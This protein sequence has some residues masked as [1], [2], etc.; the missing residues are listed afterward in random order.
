[1]VVDEEASNIAGFYIGIFGCIFLLSVAIW[2]GLTSNIIGGWIGSLIFILVGV[3]SFLLGL[4]SR[5][6]ENDPTREAPILL[7]SIILMIV[8]GAIAIIFII[9][10]T[11]FH[12]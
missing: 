10:S 2:G 5:Y 3:G 12:K 8:A 6:R 7:I 11:F 4:S 1:M 9:I